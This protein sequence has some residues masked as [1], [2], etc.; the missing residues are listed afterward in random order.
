ML[1]LFVSEQ[2]RV[3][4]LQVIEAGAV[5]GP[6]ETAKRRTIALNALQCAAGDENGLN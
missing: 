3:A 1:Q 4:A 2:Q 6:S 5:S